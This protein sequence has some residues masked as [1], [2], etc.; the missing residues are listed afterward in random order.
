MTIYDSNNRTLIGNYRFDFFR[1]RAAR[2]LHNDEYIY[3]FGDKKNNI[4][5]RGTRMDIWNVDTDNQDQSTGLMGYKSIAM[6]WSSRG[7]GIY[8]HNWWRSSFDIGQFNS[9]RIEITVD[10]G[11]MDFYLFYGPSFRRLLDQYTELTGKPALL[12]KWAFGFHQGGA[13]NDKTSRWATEIADNMRRYHL[14]IDAIYYDDV[15]PATFTPDFAQKMWTQFHVRITAGYGMPW[16]YQGTSLWNELNRL[17]PKGM[18][19][20]REGKAL[21]HEGNGMKTPF[22]EIDFFNPAASD[23]TFQAKWS[24]PL[25]NGV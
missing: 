14:P 9:G 19:V 11:E 24:G 13:G 10:G 12:P 3:G 18:I 16:A 25:R 21:L 4:D 15:D 7:Y 17:T 2:D 23:A 20:D 1:L 8:L 22:S 6:Y 5:K